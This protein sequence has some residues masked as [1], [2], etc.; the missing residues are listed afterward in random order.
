ML[1]IDDLVD[2]FAVGRRL[3]DLAQGATLPAGLSVAPGCWWTAHRLKQRGWL[4]ARLP[5]AIDNG[6]VGDDHFSILKD[7]DFLAAFCSWLEP[8]GEAQPARIVESEAAD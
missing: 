7:E 8:D 4:E 5:N 3:K 1:G 2:A 6:V